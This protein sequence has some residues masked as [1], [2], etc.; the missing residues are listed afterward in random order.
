MERKWTVLPLIA[1]LATGC[2][3]DAPGSP[4]GAVTGAGVPASAA[5]VSTQ[6]EGKTQM[7]AVIPAT[8]SE[9]AAADAGNNTRCVVGA[10]TDDDGLNQKPVV[11]VVE[12]SGARVLRSE[13]LALPSLAYQARATHC[14]GA[15]GFLYV[16]IQSD[17]Q[18]EQTLS[19]TLL[20]IVKIDPASG[21]VIASADI[22]PTGVEDAHSAWVEPGAGTFRLQNH[23]LAIR[24][25]YYRLAD[26]EARKPFTVELSDTLVQ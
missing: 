1:T 7:D 16:L 26:P 9:Y 21:A 24:G 17:T 11:L 12:Q 6:D 22:D 13:T 14:R 18:P 3:A 20:R 15:D 4:H 10:T 19:Q 5:Q 23:K 8:F 2:A 25:M